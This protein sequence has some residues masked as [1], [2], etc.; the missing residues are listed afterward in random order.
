MSDTVR[1]KAEAALSEI[2]AV[3]AVILPRPDGDWQSV[4]VSQG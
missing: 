3:T 1:Q 2:E 4:F